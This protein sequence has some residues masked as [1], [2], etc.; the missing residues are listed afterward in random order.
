[1]RYGFLIHPIIMLSPFSFTSLCFNLF[2][3]CLHQFNF[4]LPLP[5]VFFDLSPNIIM[6]F[7]KLSFL[8]QLFGLTL[9]EFVLFVHLNQMKVLIQKF[10]L[11]LVLW[12]PFEKQPLVRSTLS[13]ISLEESLQSFWRDKLVLF[14]VWENRFSFR[15]LIR[16]NSGLG[17]TLNSL[18]SKLSLFGEWTV[19]FLW[20][21]ITVVKG[22][23]FVPVL[24]HRVHA[25]RLRQ[26]GQVW[27]LRFR[28]LLGRRSPDTLLEAT[29]H[30]DRMGPRGH[31]SSQILQILF[32]ELLVSSTGHIAFVIYVH[33]FCIQIIILACPRRL[34]FKL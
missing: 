2:D 3:S 4:I 18:E 30:V 19:Y 24:R 1:M 11:I 23:L 14:Q 21:L 26:T 28:T 8:G 25:R 33:D 22:A 29:F 5:D 32:V 17:P 9:S 31:S 34:I 27:K 6:N 13:L 16:L 20:L 7:P 10:T 15:L 12:L